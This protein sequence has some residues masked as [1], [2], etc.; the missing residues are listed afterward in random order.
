MNVKLYTKYYIYH[1]YIIILL[2]HKKYLLIIVPTIGEILLLAIF[3]NIRSRW[4]FS[5]LYKNRF[6]YTVLYIDN[7][8]IS[9]VCVIFKSYYIFN[10]KCLILSKK[11]KCDSYLKNRRL[12][13]LKKLFGIIM[14]IFK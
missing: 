8:S 1:S 13:L 9:L 3:L 5:M 2:L 10:I 6:I 11:K 12:Y 7:S 4:P 14:H